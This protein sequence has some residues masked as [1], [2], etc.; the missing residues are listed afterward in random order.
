[1]LTVV[2]IGYAYAA[3]TKLLL[4]EVTY[5][6]LQALMQTTL[7]EHSGNQSDLPR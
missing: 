2:G 5:I 1:M 3:I 7:F 4:D 6:W